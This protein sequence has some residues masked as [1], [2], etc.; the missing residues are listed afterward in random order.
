[1]RAYEWQGLAHELQMHLPQRRDRGPAKVLDFDV[2]R[3]EVARWLTRRKCLRGACLRKR[4]PLT[5]YATLSPA[6]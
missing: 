1:M 5:L 2:Y 3:I 6:L 4:P